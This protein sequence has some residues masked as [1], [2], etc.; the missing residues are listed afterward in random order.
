[1]Q[2]LTPLT[3]EE[4]AK[5]LY[6]EKMH[7]LEKRFIIR[8]SQQVMETCLKLAESKNVDLEKLKIASWL[9]DIGRTEQDKGHAEKSVEI[10]EKEF[11]FLDETIKD[12]ILNHG[13]SKSP[14]TEEGKIIQF[15]DKL[16]IL[17]DYEIIKM[18]F[19]KPEYKERSVGFLKMVCD[20]FLEMLERYEW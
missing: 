3:A 7:G 5:K 12:C 13:N 2:P 8:H 16:S 17:N 4:F 15:A 1:M 20:D 19:E 9:H 10:A 14:Q 18:A 6:E 11:G